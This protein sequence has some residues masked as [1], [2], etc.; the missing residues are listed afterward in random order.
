[1][2]ERKKAAAAI[3]AKLGALAALAPPQ[4]SSSPSVE[5]SVSP[6]AEET[7]KG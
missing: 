4:P 3:A 6:P 7:P 1:M 2:D 5:P